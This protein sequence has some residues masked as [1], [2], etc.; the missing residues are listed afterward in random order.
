MGSATYSNGDFALC[1]SDVGYRH[2][3]K[4]ANYLPAPPDPILANR[5]GGNNARGYMVKLAGWCRLFA[6][7]PVVAGEPLWRL[8]HGFPGQLAGGDQPYRSYRLLH[9]YCELVWNYANANAG[10]IGPRRAIVIFGLDWRRLANVKICRSRRRRKHASTRYL[11]HRGEIIGLAR[12]YQQDRLSG[13]GHGTCVIGTTAC[14]ACGGRFHRE[15]HTA[16]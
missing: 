6:T 11:P 16:I 3:T 15:N 9:Y 5:S 10:P 12:L 1:S 8:N 14:R 13:N 2:F 7:T 4:T